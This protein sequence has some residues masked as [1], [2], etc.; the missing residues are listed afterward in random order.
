M[1][2][3]MIAQGSFEEFPIWHGTAGF[4]NPAPLESPDRRI[5]LGI[6]GHVTSSKCRFADLTDAKGMDCSCMIG[7]TIFGTDDV[8]VVMP[9]ARKIGRWMCELNMSGT[10]GARTHPVG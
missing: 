8:R 7:L 6:D 9:T 5:A 10:L 1:V 2:P 3:G 4:M